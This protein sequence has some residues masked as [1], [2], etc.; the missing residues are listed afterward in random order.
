MSEQL[1]LFTAARNTDP[2]T[3]QANRDAFVKKA[4]QRDVILLTYEIEWRNYDATFGVWSRTDGGLTD[5]ECG[6]KTP[7]N[8][9]T[10]YVERVCYWKRCSE[11]R[12]LGFIEPLG[13]TRESFAGQQQQVCAITEKGRE[14]IRNLLA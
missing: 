11:L 9:S 10:M 2:A 5:E 4:S 14:H 8:G 12:K 13:W 1:G 6:M 7:W 3:S